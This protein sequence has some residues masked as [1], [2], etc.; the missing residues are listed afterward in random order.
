MS[1]KK[2][3][4][5]L[6]IL[7]LCLSLC[8][9]GGE[10]VSS[11][12][13]FGTESAEADNTPADK[14]FG[15]LYCSKDPINPYTATTKANQELCLLMFDSLFKLD[16]NF[17]LINSMAKTHKIDRKEITVNL[18]SGLKFS[19]ASGVTADDVVFS[20]LEAKKSQ[21]Y[22]SSLESV[23]SCVKLSA[24]SV[25]FIF[26]RQDEFGVNLLTFPILKADSTNRVDG[27]NVA[28]PPIGCGRYVFDGE[29]AALIVNNFY[30]SAAPNIKK[31]YL[32]NAPDNE[33]VEHNIKVG[34]S[35]IYYNSTA[36]EKT[37]RMNN[38]E[39]KYLNTTN[40]VYLG[41]NTKSGV[42]ANSYV[43]YAVSAA[44][45]RTA[46]AKQSYYAAAVPATGIYHPDFEPAKAYQTIQTS[47]KKEISVV[48]LEQIGYNKLDSEGY[49][50]NKSGKRLN[51]SV[52]V[53][54]D[55]PSR[56]A[57]AELIVSSLK[58]VGIGANLKAVDYDKYVAMLSAGQFDFYL[59]EVNLT[60][61]MDI[62]ALCYPD[63][64][65]AY[66]IADTKPVTEDT[67]SETETVTDISLSVW[68]ILDRFYSGTATVADIVN[69]FESELPVIP[70]CY[71]YASLFYNENFSS[72]PDGSVSDIFL[73]IENY[74]F[75]EEIK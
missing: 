33:V 46:V 41:A 67:S 15:L 52:L 34:Y 58:V 60:P 56:L 30:R 63:G 31:I 68:Q 24:D 35:D 26:S 64:S 38:S 62:S 16:N 10:K 29:Q 39:R 59:G 61:N 3:I 45:D 9:C 44:L 11:E 75:K 53:N 51:V 70:V 20:F 73:G 17:K 71:R 5:V 74:A 19:D 50:V 2:T 27:D 54:S 18:K 42:A 6:L 13:V 55:N 8:A 4:S 72:V 40:L 57:A 36:D 65:V 69:I 25:K 66:G 48:N 23:L 14:K 37:I 49:Y 47:P 7:L 21:N 22:S 1:L 12:E 28:L 32:T 43:R